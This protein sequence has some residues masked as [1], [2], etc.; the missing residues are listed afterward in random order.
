MKA[1]EKELKKI[2]GADNPLFG[3]ILLEM[4]EVRLAA[5]VRAQI[6]GAA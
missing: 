3:R 5:G 2:E 1:L 6:G 4:C